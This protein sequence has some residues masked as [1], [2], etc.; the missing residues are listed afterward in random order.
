MGGELFLMVVFFISAF[1]IMYHHAIFPFL[2]SRY[3]NKYSSNQDFKHSIDEELPTIT[4]VIPVFNEETFI[5]DKV[6]NLSTLDYPEDKLNFIFAFDGCTDDSVRIA[7]EALKFPEC[8]HMRVELLE[9]KKNRGKVRVLN[10]VL[11]SIKSDI[12]ALSDVSALVSIDALKVAAHHFMDQSVGVVTG[13]YELLTPLTENEKVYWRYQSKIKES[14]SNFSSIMGAHGALYF[15]RTRLNKPLP[16]DAINDDFLLPMK[17][18]QQGYKAKYESQINALELEGSSS[19]NDFKR[20]LRISAGNTQQLIYLFPLL[21]PLHGRVFILFFSGKFLRWLTPYL[22][23]LM[24]FNSFILS[25]SNVFFQVMF[26]LQSLIYIWFFYSFKRKTMPKN[27]YS[28]LFHYLLT[29]HYAGLVGSSHYLW[30]RQKIS[31]S[32]NSLEN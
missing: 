12:T 24:L 21:N 5:R 18:V 14:E 19:E 25:F 8:H 3:G 20:R 6:L 30:R 10:E 32:S 17:I 27:K 2:L 29:G 13:H 28:R 7:K 11:P 4:F 22:L 23:I 15:F 1:F 31:W 9:F 16:E 26:V